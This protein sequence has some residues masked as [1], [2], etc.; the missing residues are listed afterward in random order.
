[1]S[2]IQARAG[3]V[4]IS[5]A[6]SRQ[7]E[8]ANGN[9]R[10]TG[11]YYSMRGLATENW[12]GLNTALKCRFVTKVTFGVISWREILDFIGQFATIGRPFGPCGLL[13]SRRSA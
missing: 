9:R 1:V 2:R 10:L 7:A 4:C 11:D 6:A 13:L 8:D 5:Q 12:M 3:R